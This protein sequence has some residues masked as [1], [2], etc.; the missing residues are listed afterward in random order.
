MRL[1][2]AAAALREHAHAPILPDDSP[3]YERSVA[4]VR[5]ALGDEAFAASW[6]AG[7]TTPLERVIADVQ[8]S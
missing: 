4:A 5:T 7:R 6:E 1:Y 3:R 2:G 8:T